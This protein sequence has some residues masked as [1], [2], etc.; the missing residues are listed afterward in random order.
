M[1]LFCLRPLIYLLCLTGCGAFLYA[2]PSGED[3]PIYRQID[4]IIG[5]ATD[6]GLTP[7]A[8]SSDAEFVRR[9]YLDLNG[10]IPTA[11][12]AATFL[13]DPSADKRQQ[14]I[15]TLLASPEYA[16]GFLPSLM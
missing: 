5:R 15:E 16:I 11:L 7:A 8:I 4:Q 13:D 12:Q 2:E 14:L 1:F 9:I 6:S 10:I 3:L